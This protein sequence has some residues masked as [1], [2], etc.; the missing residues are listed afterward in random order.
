MPSNP[1]T[2]TAPLAARGGRGPG[3]SSYITIFVLCSRW[4][5]PN[6]THPSNASRPRP[7]FAPGRSRARAIHLVG[8]SLGVLGRLHHSLVDVRRR[9]ED[10]K[11]ERHQEHVGQVGLELI[12][13]SHGVFDDHYEVLQH[14]L[15][16]LLPDLEAPAGQGL[17]GRTWLQHLLPESGAPMA[18]AGK[19]GELLEG[20]PELH[21][22][23]G[24]EY[25]QQPRHEEEDEGVDSGQ[26]LGKILLRLC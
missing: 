13:R 7:P 26:H 12:R 22:A 25:D 19:A 21:E 4:S 8:L 20:D 17:K 23:D 14:R 16:V 15:Q 1:R 11:D 6:T 3:R 10:H 9:G 24:R 5:P 18:G 2:G